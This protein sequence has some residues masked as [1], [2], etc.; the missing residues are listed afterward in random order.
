MSF[1]CHRARYIKIGTPCAIPYM[2]ISGGS[3]YIAY[4]SLSAVKINKKWTYLDMDLHGI[5]KVFVRQTHREI[6]KNLTLKLKT[7]ILPTLNLLYQLKM[8]FCCF[9]SWA[10]KKDEFCLFSFVLIEQLIRQLSYQMYQVNNI[11]SYISPKHFSFWRKKIYT[12][13]VN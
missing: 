4:L 11:S 10:I 6:I 5:H 8:Q 7:K 12:I 13:R 1:L 9:I 3:D 2:L